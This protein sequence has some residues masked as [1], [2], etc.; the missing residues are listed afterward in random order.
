V[1]QELSTVNVDAKA[2][3]LATQMLATLDDLRAC[4]ARGWQN[5]DDAIG[6]ESIDECS[7][8]QPGRIERGNDGQ[9]VGQWRRARF[10]KTARQISTFGRAGKT[11]LPVDC[12][13][14]AIGSEYRAKEKI[15]FWHGKSAFE[16]CYCGT[17]TFLQFLAGSNP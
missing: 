12:N 10:G 7:I 9:K 16:A 3:A 5:K 15:R 2:I 6:I 13:P 1:P 11:G 17:D 8:V 14:A 4:K